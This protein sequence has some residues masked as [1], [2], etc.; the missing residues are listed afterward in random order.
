MPIK[1]LNLSAR[2]GREPIWLTLDPL[3]RHVSVLTYR[4]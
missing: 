3:A 2:I 4:Q 1:I